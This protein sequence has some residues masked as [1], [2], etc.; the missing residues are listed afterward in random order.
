MSVRLIA[1]GSV[2]RR[3]PSSLSSR[4]RTVIDAIRYSI[5][6]S[7]I[8]YT[9]LVSQLES[10][11]VSRQID[12]SRGAEILADAW[13]MLDCL[14]RLYK[15]LRARKGFQREKSIKEFNRCL[16]GITDIRNGVQHLDTQVYNADIED[17]PALG[18]VTWSYVRD[19]AAGK[20]EFWLYVSGA[21]KRGLHKAARL[22]SEYED[23]IG[24]IRLHAYGSEVC[25]SDAY[26]ALPGVVN[27]LKSQVV[28]AGAEDSSPRAVDHFLCISVTAQD[29]KDEQQ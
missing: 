24:R 26:R 5:E 4:E 23:P 18:C 3:L 10:I 28:A 29:S 12:E 2:L 1:P 25:L 13:A 16:V 17:R 19:A 6:M 27:V 22:D 21:M 8:T 15:L 20:L 11:V 7:D 9:R 14:F